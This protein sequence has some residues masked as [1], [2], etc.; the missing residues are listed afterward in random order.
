MDFFPRTRPRNNEFA[1]TRG[2]NNTIVHQRPIG[3]GGY[4]Q[5]H[6]VRHV[7]VIFEYLFNLQM[8]RI[9]GTKEVVI[10]YSYG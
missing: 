7:F 2:A 3:S 5:V 10:L 6:E 1:W 9:K 4:G 8:R